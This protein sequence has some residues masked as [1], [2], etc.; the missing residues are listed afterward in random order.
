MKRIVFFTS[1]KRLSTSFS[2][3]FQGIS[4]VQSQTWTMEG[5]IESL[6]DGLVFAG[7][8]S[9]REMLINVPK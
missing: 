1:A 7:W 6:K 5:H 2:L 4:N 8:I 3:R 9:D